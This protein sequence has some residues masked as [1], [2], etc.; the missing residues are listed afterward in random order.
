MKVSQ[1][2][3]ARLLQL[4][5]SGQIS[6]Y[7][8]NWARRV[9]EEWVGALN[10]DTVATRERELPE[11]QILPI[12]EGGVKFIWDNGIWHIEY[13]LED[14]EGDGLTHY[15]VIHANRVGEDDYYLEGPSNTV[16]DGRMIRYRMTEILQGMQD[17]AA[18]VEIFQDLKEIVQSD[19]DNEDPDAKFEHTTVKEKK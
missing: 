15:P 1:E 6:E 3:R 9:L 13:E 17:R 12:V 14:N 11:P 19:K 7:N 10:G 5:N 4:H 18:V 8:L 2:L 16:V